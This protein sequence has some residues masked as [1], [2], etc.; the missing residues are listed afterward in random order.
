MGVSALQLQVRKSV[1]VCF[2]SLG[3]LIGERNFFF[4]TFVFLLFLK[5]VKSEERNRDVSGNMADRAENYV[6][7]F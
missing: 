6:R 2:G 5:E 3:F 1:W 4:C 7:I